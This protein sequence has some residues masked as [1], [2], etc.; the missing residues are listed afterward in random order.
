MKVLCSI[1]FALCG[2]VGIG[3]LAAAVE[4]SAESINKENKHEDEDENE[5]S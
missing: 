5:K 1:L 3:L 4:S 2:L